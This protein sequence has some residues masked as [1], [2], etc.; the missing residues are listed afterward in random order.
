VEVVKRRS[1]NPERVLEFVSK[2]ITYNGYSPSHDEIVAGVPIPA[3]LE[4]R[5]QQFHWED[6]PLV[7][8]PA[9]ELPRIPSGCDLFALVVRGN[10]MIDDGIFDGDKVVLYRP[11]S[12]ESGLPNRALVAAWIVE[13]ETITLKRYVRKQDGSVWLMPANP[14]FQPREFKD[15]ERE[16]EIHGVVVY[17]MRRC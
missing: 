1:L 6:T 10:S 15:P 12:V 16:L 14:E 5:S 7:E 17:L 4:R 8:V 11:Q 13:D 2:Y 3:P 9:A